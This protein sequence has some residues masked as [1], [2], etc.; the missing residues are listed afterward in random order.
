VSLSETVWA[1]TSY[2]VQEMLT[3]VLIFL[4]IIYNSTHEGTSDKTQF[5]SDIIKNNWPKFF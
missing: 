1:G 5:L 4:E 2:L 3:A